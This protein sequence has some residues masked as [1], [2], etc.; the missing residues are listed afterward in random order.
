[1]GFQNKIQLMDSGRIPHETIP[2]K[3]ESHIDKKAIYLFILGLLSGL[4]AFAGFLTYK[5]KFYRLD[6]K[7]WNGDGL[8]PKLGV[9]GDWII[10]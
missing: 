10:K 9:I 1:M 7:R 5:E 6:K 8:K 3:S 4:T 2:N